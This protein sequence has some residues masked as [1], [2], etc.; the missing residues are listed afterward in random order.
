MQFAGPAS[1]LSA[2]LL[3]Q[4]YVS[5]TFIFYC[6]IISIKAFVDKTRQEENVLIAKQSTKMLSLSVRENLKLFPQKYD[7]I[8]PTCSIRSPFYHHK[9]Y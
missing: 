1:H 5:T 7:K 2:F 6:N 8:L 4:I 3:I 9:Q